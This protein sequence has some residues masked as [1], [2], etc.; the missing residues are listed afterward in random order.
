MK[1]SL[2]CPRCAHRR[3]WRVPEIQEHGPGGR[4]QPLGA[5]QGAGPFELFVCAACGYA[6]WYA[7]APQS[8]AARPALA[9]I[10]LVDYRLPCHECGLH[11]HVLVARFLEARRTPLLTTQVVPVPGIRLTDDI[12]T[13]A[14][15]RI[16][17]RYSEHVPLA[18]I[19]SHGV[20]DGSFAVTICRHCGIGAWYAC[21][22]R[23]ASCDPVSEACP[24]CK[25]ADRVRVPLFKEEDGKKLP[26]VFAWRA[27][28]S[29]RLDVCRACGFTE[30]FAELGDIHPG[31]HGVTLL[32]GVSTSSPRERNPYR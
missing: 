2:T 20:A 1:Q 4:A 21:D 30:W 17:T 26:V 9:V 3:I 6:E 12:I 8:L 29:F 32:E 10:E 25:S 24:R 14:E 13:P 5:P 22:F 27:H 7:S 11:G 18:V 19:R 31:R 15:S 16:T 23:G 28:G